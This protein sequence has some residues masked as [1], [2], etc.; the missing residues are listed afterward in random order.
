MAESKKQETIG[1]E[2]AVATETATTKIETTKDKVVPA[3]KGTVSAPAGESSATE[4]TEE[5]LPPTTALD[6]LEA[7]PEAD[8]SGVLVCTY[9]FVN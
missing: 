9:S 3:E 7:D 8:G 1:L 6:I 4:A 2:E 5:S